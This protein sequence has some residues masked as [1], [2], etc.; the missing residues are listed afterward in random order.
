MLLALGKLATQEVGKMSHHNQKCQNREIVHNEKNTY[1]K[2]N[3]AKNLRICGQIFVKLAF[4]FCSISYLSLVHSEVGLCKLLFKLLVSISWKV[5]LSSL[6][7]V[8]ENQFV[9]L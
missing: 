2:I 1:K 4:I 7:E 6:A 9:H 3:D 5:S 8:F